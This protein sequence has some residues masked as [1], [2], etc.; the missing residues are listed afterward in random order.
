MVGLGSR[1]VMSSLAPYARVASGGEDAP[2]ETLVDVLAVHR[3][4]RHKFD[5]ADGCRRRRR[6]AAARGTTVV[7]AGSV[8]PG[9]AGAGVSRL[10]V[11]AG[12]RRAACAVPDGSVS[13]R[14]PAM[15]DAAMSAERL[16]RRCRSA[17]CAYLDALQSCPRRSS[18]VP[19]CVDI[20]TRHEDGRNMAAKAASRGC[21]SLPREIERA[22]L[23]R[24]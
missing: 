10:G 17:S 3:Q 12:R 2:H 9:V 16:A 21:G 15:A 14:A 6:S 22:M 23:F 1:L 11:R 4:Q 24:P 8:G 18:P 13:W 5:L 20:S 19:G 7:L